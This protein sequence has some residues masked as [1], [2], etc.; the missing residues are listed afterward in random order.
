M[1]L[2]T[3]QINFDEEIQRLEQERAKIAEQ[4]ASLADDNPERGELIEE[5]ASIDTYLQG[6]S[7]A[8][9]EWDADSIT[10]SGLTGGEFGRVEDDVV[11]EAAAQGEQPGSG[12]T[13]VYLVE[14]GTVDA[15]YV[16]DDMGDDARVGAVSQLPIT[17]LKFAEHKVNELTT[18]GNGIEQSF[19]SLLAEKQAESRDE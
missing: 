15:P 12:A 5:G 11:S 9:N 7:W 16:D 14:S 3:E 4:A 10:L 19:S 8:R 1:P 17:F 18:V 6:L 13:R 2:Q